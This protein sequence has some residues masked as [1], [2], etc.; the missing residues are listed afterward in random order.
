PS[1]DII[2]TEARQYLKAHEFDKAKK[3]LYPLYIKG[4]RNNSLLSSV[5]LYFTIKKDYLRSAFVY[6]QLYE[7]NPKNRD[8]KRYMILNL[9]YAG[10]P[11]KAMEWLKTDPTLLS[12]AETDKI[13]TDIKALK[14]RWSGYT[15]TEKENQADLVDEILQQLQEVLSVRRPKGYDYNLNRLQ[16][17]YIVAL[18]QRGLTQ[19]VLDQYAL[20]YSESYIF[21]DYVLSAVAAAYLS[22]HQ[23]DEAR[24]LYFD[25]LKRNPHSFALHE[26]LFWAYFDNGDFNKGIELAEALDAVTPLWRKDNIGTIIK[27]NNEKLETALLLAMGKAYSNDLSGAQ[28]ELERMAKTAPYN[29]NILYNLA[30]LYRWRGWP[31]KAYETISIATT[32]DPEQLSL[33]ISKAFSL[34]EMYH[35]QEANG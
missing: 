25:L 7:S 28:E 5:A 12:Q 2:I 1:Q 23:P 27:Q 13:S 6:L 26:G 34:F 21:P 30:E 18:H 32:I 29:Q 33:R 20:L 15:L 9:F 10:A 11:F 31:E 8:A 35:F 19:E 3:L 14:I 22:N 24:K 17:D 16:M 4:K